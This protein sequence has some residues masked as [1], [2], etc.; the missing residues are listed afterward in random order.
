[1][2]R[3]LEG[4]A[5]FVDGK[6]VFSAVSNRIQ[7]S[8]GF[9]IRIDR[10]HALMREKKGEFRKLFR[11]EGNLLETYWPRDAEAG[12]FSAAHFGAGEKKV[13]IVAKRNNFV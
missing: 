4:I 11:E 2:L 10:D 8:L 7:D 1:M 5:M 9:H 3:W 12:V 13:R 6:E